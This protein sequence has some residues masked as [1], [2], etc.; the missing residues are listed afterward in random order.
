MA[1]RSTYLVVAGLI[2]EGIY[3]LATWRL[4]W[5]AFEGGSW[6]WVQILGKG[7]GPLLSC[8]TSVLG[9]MAAYLW[10]WYLVRKVGGARRIVWSFSVAFA[11]TLFWLLPITCDLSSY[12]TKAHLFTDL[13]ANP[14]LEAPADFPDGLLQAYPA[15]YAEQPSVYG[16]VWALLSG[17]GT[18][19]SHDE[20]AGVFY[21]KA[22]AAVAYLGAVWLLERIV[23]KVRPGSAE[24]VLYLFAWNPLVL[25]MAIGDGHNDIVMMAMILLAAWLLLRER[26]V[27]AFGVLVL[28]AWI[29]YASL[30][31]LPLFA[32]YAWRQLERE[33][34]PVRWRAVAQ[35]ALAS[36]SV[37]IL[38]FVPFGDVGGVLQIGRRLL[39]PVNWQ[40]GANNL[41]SGA[42]GAGLLIFCGAY[43]VLLVWFIRGQ[44]SFEPLGNAG[45]AALLLVFVLGFAR[46]QPWHLIWPASLAGLADRRWAWP[47]VVGLSGILLVVQLWVEWGMPGVPT[48]RMEV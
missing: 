41:V 45:F 2:T 10:G 22:L 39:Q 20:V 25:F 42:F 26:W 44:G 13:R 16:P 7:A 21:L 31:L 48:W 5:W 38:V 33:P 6:N 43:L 14:L 34:C 9:L 30:T 32:L 19:G 1:R 12:L 46:S 8:V 37:T 27:L 11:A 17:L 23:N 3:L 40:M 15:A 28:S 24:E 29:K 47:A 35:A 4:P 36:I 18:L